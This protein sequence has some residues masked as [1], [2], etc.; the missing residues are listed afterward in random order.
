MIKKFMILINA[1]LLAILILP[2]GSIASCVIRKG[3]LT[4]TYKTVYD[5]DR[6]TLVCSGDGSLTCQWNTGDPAPIAVM[7]NGNPISENEAIQIVEQNISNGIIDGDVIGD[8]QV[9][10]YLWYFDS[11]GDLYYSFSDG[12]DN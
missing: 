12:Q 7:V 2:F 10:Y 8:N 5:D 6:G 1:I 9:G 3:H 4:G 11:N